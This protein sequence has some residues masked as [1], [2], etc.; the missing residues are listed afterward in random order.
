LHISA[1]NRTIL[2]F[3]YWYPIALSCAPGF[4]QIA[5]SCDLPEKRTSSFQPLCCIQYNLANMNLQHMS[6]Q[7]KKKAREEIAKTGFITYDVLLAHHPDV[8]NHFAGVPSQ[9][10]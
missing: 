3:A 4:F 10:A 9:D 1:L 8:D 5:Q 7:L 2:Q 6:P